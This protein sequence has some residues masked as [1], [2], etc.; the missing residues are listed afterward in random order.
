M[1]I[2]ILNYRRTRCDIGTQ[3]RVRDCSPTPGWCHDNTA[4]T[5][6][7]QNNNSGIVPVI[8]DGDVAIQERLCFTNCSYDY[9]LESII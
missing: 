2:N 1:H 8:H 3:L 7:G 4:T 5:L 9:G 6:I